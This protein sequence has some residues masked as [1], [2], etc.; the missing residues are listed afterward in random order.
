MSEEIRD[1]SRVLPLGM[2]WTLIL[3][4]STG[5]VMIITLAFCVGDIDHVLESQTGFAFIQ[6]FLNSTGSVRAATGMTVVIMAM[7]FCAAISN[8]ATTS[9][10]VYAFAR[11]KGLPFSNFLSTVNPTFIVPLNALCMSLAIVSLLSL[12]NIGSSVAFNAIMSLAR[13]LSIPHTSSPSPAFACVD[14][15]I[16]LCLPPA[17]A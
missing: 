2:I 7:Q 14:G 4:G 15:A 1:A 6:V 5:F 10:Q 3:N 12:I 9:R 13:Q 11:D 8:V 16:S 17:G